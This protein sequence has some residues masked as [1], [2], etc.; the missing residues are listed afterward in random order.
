M[1]LAGFMKPQPMR[2]TAIT[3]ETFV[4]TM[5]LLTHDD[6]CV[7]RASSSDRINRM[8]SAGMFMMP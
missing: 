2:M 1:W 3:M 5:M 4:M 6:S 7:P 8:A